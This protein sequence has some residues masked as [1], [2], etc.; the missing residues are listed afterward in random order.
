MFRP[1]WCWKGALFGCGV[2]YAPLLNS[3]SSKKAGAKVL[4][5]GDMSES[6]FFP[7]SEGVGYYWWFTS[8]KYVY[9]AS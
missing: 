6:S 5:C 1:V 4:F 2:V 3:D 7:V 9:V 8:G